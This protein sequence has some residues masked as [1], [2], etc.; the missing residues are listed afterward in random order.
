M[1]SN[2]QSHVCQCQSTRRAAAILLDG[3]EDSLHEFQS[4]AHRMATSYSAD[5]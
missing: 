2:M 3:L 5:M 4:I 1:A